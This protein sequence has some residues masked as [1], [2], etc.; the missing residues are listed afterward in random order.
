[1]TNPTEGTTSAVRLFNI[2]DVDGQ[3]AAPD[4][5]PVL[6][7]LAPDQTTSTPTVSEPTTGV[8]QAAVTWDEG[9][10][11]ELQWTY[12][13]DGFSVVIPCRQCVDTDSLAVVSA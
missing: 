5:T 2:L 10:W 6:T 1:M 8:Y 12:T 9:G 4:A 13:V 3:P 7:V 11:W